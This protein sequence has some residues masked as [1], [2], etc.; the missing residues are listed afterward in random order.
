M[1]IQ[2]F[3][4][5]QYQ[6]DLKDWIKAAIP[7]SLMSLFGIGLLLWVA[8]WE[9]LPF[10]PVLLFFIAV[11]MLTLPHINLVGSLYG[12]VSSKYEVS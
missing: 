7:F 1:E 5:E 2:A 4:S 3:D 9:G 11:S 12:K 8:A 6:F 10:H